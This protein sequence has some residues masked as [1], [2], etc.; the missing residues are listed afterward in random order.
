M[1][2]P[3]CP[4]KLQKGAKLCALSKQISPI[5]LGNDLESM[6]TEPMFIREYNEQSSLEM[7]SRRERKGSSCRREE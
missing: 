4:H 2:V 1:I 6:A 7:E 5:I 3:C